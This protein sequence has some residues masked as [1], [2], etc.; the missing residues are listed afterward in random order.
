MPKGEKTNVQLEEELEAVYETLA[1]KDKK[2]K[3]LEL[4]L[5]GKTVKPPVGVKSVQH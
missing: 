2:I 5:K 1:E 3:S 4:K